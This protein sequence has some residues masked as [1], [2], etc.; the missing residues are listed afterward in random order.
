MK[1]DY[2]HRIPFASKTTVLYLS[3]L[4]ALSLIVPSQSFPETIRAL[5]FVAVRFGALL[6]IK[7]HGE[8]KEERVRV[9]EEGLHRVGLVEPG[10]VLREA[11][12]CS[13]EGETC[14]R[15]AA[16]P[17][18]VCVIADEDGGKVHRDPHGP[19]LGDDIGIHPVALGERLAD[20][21]VGAALLLVGGEAVQEAVVVRRG[22]PELLGALEQAPVN[23]AGTYLCGGCPYFAYFLVLTQIFIGS[24]SIWTFVTSQSSFHSS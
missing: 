1:V 20:L 14:S 17:W 7:N 18:D 12:P 3:Y 24:N 13:R 11:V 9:I 21:G 2:F 19:D 16:S 22:V 23:E 10:G 5:H 6:C 4:S 8:G 15:P